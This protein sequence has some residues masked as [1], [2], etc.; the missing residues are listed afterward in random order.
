MKR[1][2]KDSDAK[3][4]YMEFKD[5]DHYLSNQ[6]NRQDFFIGLDKF[7]KKN[8]GESEISP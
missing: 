4:T 7:L 5:E 2:L 8:L 1:A 6:K 3:V